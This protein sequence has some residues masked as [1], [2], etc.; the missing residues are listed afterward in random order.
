MRP[1]FNV[2][3]TFRAFDELRRGVLDASDIKKGLKGLGIYPS[4][5]DLDLFMRRFDAGDVRG[6]RMS[7]FREVFSPKSLEYSS[8]LDSRLSLV[9]EKFV[10]LNKV[11][12]SYNHNSSLLIP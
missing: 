12:S 7:S 5:E 9:N 8:L 4:R 1:D 3:D 11:S 6:L 10:P 2:D